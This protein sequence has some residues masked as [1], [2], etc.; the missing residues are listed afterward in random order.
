MSP[1]ALLVIDYSNDF[2]HDEGSFSLGKSGQALDAA[3]VKHMEEAIS[4]GDYIFICNDRHLPGDAHHPESGLFPPHNLADSWG[5]KLYG[6]TGELAEALLK[7]N[8][9]QVYFLPKS[10]FSA[11]VGT[12]LSLLLRERKV[13]TLILAGVC[14]DICILHTAI[15]GWEEGFEIQIAADAC[16]TTTSA[17]Q[18]WALNHFEHVLGLKILK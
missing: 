18:A 14:T 2:I 7:E 10:R 11:F 5:E 6:K 17:G 1:K 4:A 9:R 13:E 15:S 8:P 16:Q 12:P 3:M